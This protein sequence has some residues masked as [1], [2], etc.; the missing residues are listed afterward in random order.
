MAKLAVIVDGGFIRTKLQAVHSKKPDSNAIYQTITGVVEKN[1]P[2]YEIFRIF[3]YDSLA[4]DTDKKEYNH[5]LTGKKTSLLEGIDAVYSDKLYSELKKRD[6]LAFRYGELGFSGWRMKKQ[7]EFMK[8]LKAKT[9]IT[10]GDFCINIKQKGVDL[11]MGLDIAWISMK[12]IVD[13][14]LIISA[15]SDLVP[16]LKFAR[17]EGLNV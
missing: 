15:D 13:A 14:I 2:N 5:P 1:L 6:G 12:R 10:E 7:G 11:K 8:K 16:A 3:Y 4:I 9:E 17:K